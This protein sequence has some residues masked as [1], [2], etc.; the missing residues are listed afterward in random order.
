M[1][2]LIPAT[3][4]DLEELESQLRKRAHAALGHEPGVRWYN[5]PQ[6]RGMFSKV[7]RDGRMGKPFRAEAGLIVGASDWIGHVTLGPD[8]LRSLA[9]A[10]RSVAMFSA[11]EWKVPGNSP[12]PE[13]VD[14]I[15]AIHAAGG[16][17]GWVDN[18]GAARIA[19]VRARRGENQ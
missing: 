9:D 10:G 6:V 17:A 13:Q 15:K 5:N 4:A 2:K 1:P 11:L 18:I 19:M 12:T 14:F 7:L 3:P 8:V 16:F